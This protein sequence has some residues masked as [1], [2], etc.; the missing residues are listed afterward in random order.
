EIFS[1]KTFTVYT[2]KLNHKIACFGYR[3]VEHDHPG[4][5]QVEK[6]RAAQVPSGPIYG[7]LKAGKV[8]E[9]PDGRVLD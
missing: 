3:V 5:L 9:L 6:L 2:K 4:E 7:Q 1:D 8:V